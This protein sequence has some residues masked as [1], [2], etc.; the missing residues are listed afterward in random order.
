MLSFFFWQSK[1]Y[2]LPA[3]HASRVY[4]LLISH[5]QLH[6]K[7]KY[8][9]TIASTIRLQVG[10]LSLLKCFYLLLHH[11]FVDSS[12]FFSGVWLLPH[13]ACRLS[14]PSW[15]PKQRWC[16]E[17][18]SL[19]LLW[20]RV[21]TQTFPLLKVKAYWQLSNILSLVFVLVVF[22]GTRE[23]C[24]WKEASRFNLSSCWQPCSSCCSSHFSSLNTLSLPSL[25]ACLQ[26]PPAVPQ[27]GT[28]NNYCIKQ[29][30][31]VHIYV[32]WLNSW[33]HA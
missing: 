23:T 12:F 28:H 29:H 32:L 3:S 15:G 25:F 10:D 33:P 11:F 14:S 6:Y 17:I 24:W 16:H 27:D 13:D 5:L 26:C 1:L 2:S 18:Q 19:L 7:N 31:T 22:Q 21:R 30:C 4:E 9:S 8:C 20:Y